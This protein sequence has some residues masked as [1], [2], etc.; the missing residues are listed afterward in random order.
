MS[1]EYYIMQGLVYA[2]EFSVTFFNYLGST[3]RTI[4]QDNIGEM[5]VDESLI[6]GES[7]PVEKLPGDKVT[8]GQGA[9]N[10]PGNIRPHGV[11]EEEIARICLLTL[12]LTDACGHRH[13]AYAG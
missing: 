4:N 9:S 3:I 10:N 2:D 12:Y 11:H 6:T 5:E 13:S 8:G 1:N 7:I